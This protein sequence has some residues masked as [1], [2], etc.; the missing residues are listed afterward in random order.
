MLQHLWENSKAGTC[1]G[2]GGWQSFYTIASAL[3]LNQLPSTTLI[4]ILEKFI[5][6]D[7]TLAS[8]RM[9]TKAGQW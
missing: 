9:D 4:A 7:E 8:G 5:S 1:L 6:Q 3:H 2:I